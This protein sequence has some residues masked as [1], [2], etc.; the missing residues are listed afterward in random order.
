MNL[1]RKQTY[2]TAG[3][4]RGLKR[5]AAETGSTQAKVI[6]QALDDWLL[7]HGRGHTDACGPLEAFVGWF[8][9]PGEV[10]HDD[11]YQ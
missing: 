5:L 1:V 2:I 11:I 4:D 3:Q 10:N 7:R 8:D 6:R 9:G